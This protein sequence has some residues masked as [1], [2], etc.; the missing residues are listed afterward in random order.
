MADAVSDAQEPEGRPARGGTRHTRRV[1]DVLDEEADDC[2]EV[3]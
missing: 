1:V 3:W 2:L